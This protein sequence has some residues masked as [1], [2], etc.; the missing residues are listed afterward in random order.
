MSA[1]NETRE[2]TLTILAEEVYSRVYS[3]ED[4]GWVVRQEIF[5]WLANGDTTFIAE[6][7]GEQLAAEWL[8]YQQQAERDQA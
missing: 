1:N 4:Y 3:G 2:Q 7:T 8:E 5:D 6:A